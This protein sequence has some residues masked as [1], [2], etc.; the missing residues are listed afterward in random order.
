MSK[1]DGKAIVTSLRK[2][3][4]VEVDLKGFAIEQVDQ[5]VIPGVDKLL[6]SI[7]KAIPGGIDD[8]VAESLKP[9][10]YKEL[11]EELLKALEKLEDKIDDVI[12]GDSDEVK[13]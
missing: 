1:F 11:K 3:V 12:K 10:L 9:Q 4:K 13:A 2:H 8:A 5:L 6:A 7:C